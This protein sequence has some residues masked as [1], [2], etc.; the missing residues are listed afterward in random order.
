M[1]QLIQ[2]FCFDTANSFFW[3]DHSF[4]YQ[5]TS[6]LDSSR[7]CSLTVTSLQEIQFS[8]LNS[9]LHILHI[10]IVIF[11]FHS[12][13]HELFVAFWHIFF[14][15]ADWLRCTNTSNY[16]FTLSIDQVLAVDTFRTSRWVTCK[17]NTCTGCLTH[18]TKY[19]CLYVYS[20]SPISR[21]V[22][23]T[24]VNDSTRV[25]PRTEYSFYCSQQLFLRILWEFCS[26][27]IFRVNCFKSLNQFFQIVYSQL[28]IV[29]N[30][31]CFFYFI[32]DFFKERLRNFHNY[33]R[34]HLNETSVRIV[35]KSW[36]ASFLSK[37]FYCNIIQTQVQ[38]GIHHTWHGGS[39]TRTNRY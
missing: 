1:K 8:F 7:S 29:M 28:C 14:Q 11:Q 19:H 21:D 35:C 26:I 5:V 36:I 24:T 9:E 27:H 38:D 6:D 2:R 33:V 30:A 18:V 20:C 15:F 25:V 39:G 31:F 10:T 13:F 17:C 32:D 23:H 16:V 37:T 34:V 12:Q 3:S 22:V 4:I